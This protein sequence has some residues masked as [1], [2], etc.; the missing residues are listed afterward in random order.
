[1]ANLVDTKFPIP[2]YL[3]TQVTEF[4]EGNVIIKLTNL[5][6]DDG[7]AGFTKS[8]VDE[9]NHQILKSE[10]TIYE[11]DQLSDEDFAAVVRHELGHAFGLA[12]STDPDDLMYPVILTTHPYISQCD[13]DAIEGLYNGDER[14]EVICQT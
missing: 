10:I 9:N 7:Y 5:K 3:H 4:G 8:I 2:I 11:A 1:M 13:I 14:S 6:N 12:H